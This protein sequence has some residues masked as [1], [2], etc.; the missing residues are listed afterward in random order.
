MV[1]SWGAAIVS[2]V[3]HWSLTHTEELPMGWAV[4]ESSPS[5]PSLASLGRRRGSDAASCRV[6]GRWEYSLRSRGLNHGKNVFICR[7]ECWNSQRKRSSKMLR[8]FWFIGI[9]CVF[10]KTCTGRSHAYC[11]Q[12]SH[13]LI[14][15]HMADLLT[16]SACIIHNSDCL[17]KIY[18]L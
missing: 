11:M 5:L 2:A 17:R 18:I 1:Q 9:C 3:V 15:R 13:L 16:C 7:A 8:K 10:S 14:S 6:S 4:K 12:T